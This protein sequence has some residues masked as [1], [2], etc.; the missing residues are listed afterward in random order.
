MAIG[1]ISGQM[2]KANLLR[3]GTDLAFETNLLVLDVTNSFVGVGT[4]TPSRQLHISGTGALRLPSGTDAQ[5]G[6]AANG[7]IRY[8]SDQGQIEGYVAGAWTDLGSGSK[9]TDEDGNTGID[10]ER[11]ADQNEIHFFIESV[12]DVAHIRSDGAIE[13][14][15]LEID[16][17]TI[18][19]LS[20]NTDI[21]ITP[22]G[23]G[24]VNLNADTI[25]VGDSSGDITITTN[26]A[27][28]LI[29]ST[30]SG[31]NS[32][33]IT[34]NDGVN[35]DINLTPNGTGEVNITKVD[36]DAGAI[37]GTTIGANSAAAGTF[38][39][40]TAN[41]TINIDGDGV[42]DNIDGVIIGANL[43]ASG[44]FT[45]IVV[46]E[47]SS[48]DSTAI[49]INEALNVSGA[50]TAS[51]FDARDGNITNVGDIALDSIS[52]DNG[53]DFDITLADNQANAL[54]IKEAG[55]SYLNFA[56][57]NSSELITA[58]Q[59]FTVATG[60]TFTTD[61]ADINGGAIDGTTIGANSAA[62][63][64]FTNLTANGTINIDGDGVGDNIDGVIIGANLAA[65]GT[66]TTV[67]TSGN[68]TVGGN[69][70]VNGV[71]TTIESTTLQIEDPLLVL[72]KN[73]SGGNANTYDQGLLINRGS[74]TNQAII[75]DESADEFAVVATTETGSTAGNIAISAYAPFHASTVTASTVTVAGLSITDNNITGIRSNENLVIT[76]SGTGSVVVNGTTTF[77][78]TVFFGD[79]NIGDVGDINV[80]SVSSDNG[81]DFAFLLD[82]NQSAALT[83]KEGSTAYMTFVTTD[84]SEQIT[85]AKKLLVSNGVTFESNTVDINGGAIDGTTIGANSAAAG[86]FTNVVLNELSS[87]DSSAIQINDS[88]NISGTLNAKTLVTNDIS[89]EDS[90]T[91]QINDSL[92]V[93]GTLTA[94]TLDVNEL[95]S[96]DSSA[97]QISDGLNIN[98]TTVANT[99]SS[100]GA[101]LTG[102]TIDN[103]VIGGTTRAAG[104]FTTV[105]ANDNITIG[106][107]NKAL[108]IGVSGDL[109]IAHDG[110][111]TTIDN[112]TGI[113]KILGAS[114]SSVQIN[115]DQT[116]VDTQISGDTDA[117]LIYVDASADKIGISTATPAYI[118]D[119]A[120]TDAVRLPSGDTASRPTPA[121]G[122]IR[123]NNS[124]STYEG[125]TDGSTWTQF[126]MGVGGVAAI[127]KV[128]ATGD[129]S[130]STFTGF[131]ASAPESAA[132]VMV[133]IDNV[134]QEPTENYT[135]SS[136]NITFTSA[137]HSGARIFALVGFDA[138]AMTTGGVA[139]TQTDSVAFTSSATAIMT[140]N[141]TSYRS[142]ELFVTVTD[143]GNTEYSCMKAN[144][145][146]DGT[147]AYISVYGIVNTGS[148]DSATITASLAG[149][150]VTVSAVSTGGASAAT[151][152]YSLQAV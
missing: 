2:L 151:V 89:S 109:Q 62:A 136:N 10:V 56:T 59:A 95:F 126:A 12:G 3:S 78:G 63:G 52:A 97:I 87:A 47:L 82:D 67:D 45:T 91:I 31:T 19:G 143:A 138:G 79:N 49:Q 129:G 117:E 4:A 73:N 15:N 113:L 92:N 96:S 94:K 54:E 72:A 50:V 121:T 124:S 71:T 17:Q 75:W 83:I 93:S 86:T 22:N 38:T 36:I 128:S 140:F 135:V 25:R 146:H 16:N 149:N 103:M 57:T 102:G 11:S 39:N 100:S 130:T 141:A 112:N 18:T 148:S 44:K 20:T 21:N 29:L 46:N 76:P 6:T 122:V 26:D 58:G 110:T 111:D 40:L 139:R 118:L 127:S 98:G 48:D 43:A 85:V 55:N 134:Y 51:S 69:L 30:N 99:F 84:G 13:L 90:T 114:G 108:R 42:G 152:Q 132:N 133:Y 41:G 68:V 23:T 65:A 77:N 101:T 60:K 7:D 142:A 115:A 66:F 88:V 74:D 81:T 61:T 24:N 106:A 8:N 137:P 147:T 34:I 80:D 33:T 70:V 35:G 105:D 107:D 53:T 32:G 123:F 145:V 64:T 1:R 27:V 28:D 14:N 125:S 131:F 116:N 5:R 104:S 119:I 9:I 150:T 120:S 37:D 144:V